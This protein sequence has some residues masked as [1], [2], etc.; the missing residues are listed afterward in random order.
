MV[1][2]MSLFN[3]L[4]RRFPSLE[5][6]ALVTDSLRQICNG[7]ACCLGGLIHLGI[8]GAPHK[9]RR[10]RMP[11]SVG[12]LECTKIC[13]IRL[14][15]GSARK[16]DWVRVGRSCVSKQILMRGRAGIRWSGR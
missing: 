16:R 13:S 4:L 2:A 15:G 3:Q 12:P 5:S 11:I 6:A 10:R 8:G 14:S 9:Y 7:P 1:Q